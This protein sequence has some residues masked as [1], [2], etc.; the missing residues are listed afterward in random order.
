MDQSTN[1]T[2]SPAKQQNA[3]LKSNSG[4]NIADLSQQL[5][6]LTPLKQNTNDNIFLRSSAS[7]YQ[8]TESADIATLN[9]QL[10]KS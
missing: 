9:E 5:N 2:Q 7:R 1:A 10:E 8:P 3:M 6:K 4:L